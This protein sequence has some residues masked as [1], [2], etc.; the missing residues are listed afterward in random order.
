MK[1]I[2]ILLFSLLCSV[3]LYSQRHTGYGRGYDFDDVDKVM[4]YKPSYWLFYV[5]AG[6]LILGLPI[7]IYEKIK[8]WKGLKTG[9]FIKIV[10]NGYI[11]PT[12][13]KYN[14]NME[15]VKTWNLKEFENQFGEFS[16]KTKKINISHKNLEQ[17]ICTKGMMETIVYVAFDCDYDNFFQKTEKFRIAQTSNGCFYLY[18]KGL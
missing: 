16:Y 11:T 10:S 6:V 9:D 15:V 13:N 14:K 7:V 2:F 5:I 1:R 12:S 8:V 3:L 17:V 4:N 18:K